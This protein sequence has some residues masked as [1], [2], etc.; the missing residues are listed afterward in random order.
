MNSLLSLKRSWPKLAFFYV[1]LCSVNTSG[2]ADHD[3]TMLKGKPEEVIASLHVGKTTIAQ[4]IKI[5]GKPE[6]IEETPL[7]NTTVKGRKYQWKHGTVLITGYAYY[8]GEAK[9]TLY[10]VEIEYSD[11]AA[12]KVPNIGTGQGL[13]LGDSF[14]RLNRLYGLKLTSS[15]KSRLDLE[16]HNHNEL[17]VDFDKNGIIVWLFL[18]TGL[19]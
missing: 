16:W 15:P 4:A 12:V 19:E 13:R 3:A 10:A 1:I 17:E 18:H 8:Y 6:K 7:E 14:E 9:S 11:A 5:L 2:F